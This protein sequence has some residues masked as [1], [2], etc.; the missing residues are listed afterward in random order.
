[1]TGR[2]PHKKGGSFLGG[3][4]QRGRCILKKC[5]VETLLNDMF[6]LGFI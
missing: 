6:D 3:G 1:M 4:C 5:L 2:L